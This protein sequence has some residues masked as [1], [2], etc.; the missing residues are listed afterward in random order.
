M[1]FRFKSKQPIAKF[2]FFS[3]SLPTAIASRL[4]EDIPGSSFFLFGLADHPKHRGL[5][6]RRKEVGWFAGKQG[7]QYDQLKQDLGA[8]PSA[9]YG[10]T[11]KILVHHSSCLGWQTIL[12]TEV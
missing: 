10:L 1:C 2:G 9:R 4:S 11:G 3:S 5:V 7:I 6:Q 12:C 8:K